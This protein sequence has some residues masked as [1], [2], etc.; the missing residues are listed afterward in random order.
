M[1][2]FQNMISSITKRAQKF[3]TFGSKTFGTLHKDINKATELVMSTSGEVS[4][5]VY[6]D[7]LLNLIEDLSNE[8]LE[9][10]L[11]FLS[12]NYDIDTNNLIKNVEIY[13]LDKNERNLK[14]ISETSEPKWIELF[15][16]LNASSN[17]TSKLVTLRER[18]RSLNNPELKPFDAGLLRLFKYWFNPSFLVLEKIDWTTP[19]NILEKIIAYEAVHEINSWDDLRARLAP[20]D[21]Q[22][23]AFFHPLIP[24]DPLIFVE[25]ALCEEVP[26]SIESIIKIERNEINAENANVGI[27]YS[28]SNCQNGLLGISFGNFLIKRVA[29]KLKQELPDLNQFL[30]LSPIPG[31]MTW[32]E[33][34]APLTHEQCID[35]SCTDEDFLKQAVTYLTE[36]TREDGLPND[37]VG[38]F[39]LGN[40]AILDR[41]NL[42]ADKSTKGMMQ[43]NGLMANYLYDLEVV[44]ENHELFFKT[45]SVQ[46]SKDIKSLKNRLS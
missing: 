9:K 46:I 7:H 15:R 30:T 33:K 23:F 1:N 19:A 40:G 17:G 3:N 34:N 20:N 35:G 4:T 39:H 45:K 5:L 14:N 24:D 27:F 25:V 32:L 12:K 31:L 28:I 21:R 2:F 41:I 38:R 42:N 6:A 16:R 37:P 26:D 43:S 10:F 36:S 22:C 44:E 18:I 13:S 8:K 29:K 11:I